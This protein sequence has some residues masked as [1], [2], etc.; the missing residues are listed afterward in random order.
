MVIELNKDLIKERN[1]KPKTV[2]AIKEI[3]KFADDVVKQMAKLDPHD[4]KGVR[5]L[6]RLV[7]TWHRYQYQLQELWGFPKN[8]YYHKDYELPH[9]TCPKIDNEDFF[10]TRLRWV[11]EDCP[12]HNKRK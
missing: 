11:T 9:C 2:A 8:R 5:E 1:I 12:L 7:K 10:G 3:H 4:P 6:R